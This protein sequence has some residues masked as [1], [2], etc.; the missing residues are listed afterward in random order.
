MDYELNVEEEYEL[1]NRVKNVCYE[2]NGSEVVLKIE[3]WNKSLAKFNIGTG[4]YSFL[5]RSHNQPIISLEYMGKLGKI[6]SIS[7]DNTIRIW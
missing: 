6:V 4:E 2:I 7:K 1:K 5:M 3:H